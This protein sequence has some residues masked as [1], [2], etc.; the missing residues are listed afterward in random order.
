MLQIKPV[1]VQTSI[2]GGNDG[3]SF[4]DAQTV[5]NWPTFIPDGPNINFSHPIKQIEV[6]AGWIIDAL[7]ITYSLTDS[8]TVT[9]KHGGQTGGSSNIIKLGDNEIIAA[10]YGWAGYYDYYKKSFLI[11]ISFNIFDTKKC[12]MRT[13]GPFGAGNGVAQGTV[14]QVSDPLA[15]AGFETDSRSLIFITPPASKLKFF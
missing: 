1:L 11:Q 10:T 3:T 15:F 13:E 8:K 5:Q 6:R 14:F 9:V 4:N 12:T 2:Y 7:N